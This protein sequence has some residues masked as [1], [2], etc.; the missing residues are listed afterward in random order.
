[1]GSSEAAAMKRP[2]SHPPPKDPILLM[3]IAAVPDE[4]PMWDHKG[5]CGVIGFWRRKG[6]GDNL[7]FETG[8][9][10]NL[11]EHLCEFQPFSYCWGAA[12]TPLKPTHKGKGQWAECIWK[13]AEGQKKFTFILHRQLFLDVFR[14]TVS[15]IPLPS[16]RVLHHENELQTDHRLANLCSVNGQWHRWHHSFAGGAPMQKQRRG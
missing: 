10:E 6:P 2:A 12:E 5:D 14:A 9:G 3:R 13:P 4:I 11:T 8:R 16:C 7:K 15:K 1:M